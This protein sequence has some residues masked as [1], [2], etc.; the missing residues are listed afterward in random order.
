KFSENLDAV[1]AVERVNAAFRDRTQPWHRCFR[2][3]YIQAAN[4]TAAED[5]YDSRGYAVRKDW[6]HG[7]NKVFRFLAAEKPQK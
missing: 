1:A 2:S 4:L 5:I 3:L 7:P 6:V